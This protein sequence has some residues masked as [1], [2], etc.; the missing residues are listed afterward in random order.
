MKGLILAGG[1]G[2]R[3]YPI[4][5]DINKQLL[6]IYDKPMIYYPLTTLLENGIREICFITSP[7]DLRDFKRLLGSGSRFGAKFN[8]R[9]QKVP[10][11][12]PEAFIIAKRFINKSNIALMLG[13]NIWHGAKIFNKA[14]K[15][16]KGGSTVFAYR[17]SD[18][19]RYGVIEFDRWGQALSLEEKPER[20][21]SNYALPGFYLF[22]NRVSYI[23]RGLQ[24][25]ARGELEI[26][27]VIR[28]YLDRKELNVETLN[29]GCAWLD[30]G[31]IAAFYESANY[32]QAIEK[33]QG[34]KVGCP[35]EAALKAG[36]LPKEKLEKILKRMP[37]CEYKEY[38][39]KLL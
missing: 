14:V 6:P 37:N 1:R 8:F 13:D 27:D 18:P 3:L 11:G 33:R 19:E 35:E 32:I 17:V 23:S 28:Y 22:D 21:K 12:I 24:P 10:K 36:L 2:S 5:Q 26:T 16:F 29:R 4:S 39:K 7:H 25:S 30:A 31:T 34:I 9:V 20:P 38:L 15:N